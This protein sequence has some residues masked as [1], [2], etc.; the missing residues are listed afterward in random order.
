[1]FGDHEMIGKMTM[2]RLVLTTAILALLVEFV[3][4]HQKVFFVWYEPEIHPM[5]RGW[6]RLEALAMTPVAMLAY[7]WV[8]LPLLGLCGWAVWQMRK[9]RRTPNQASEAIGASPPQPQR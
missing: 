8:N 6:T 9:I 1:M 2:L 7:W 3:L 4:V 5:S